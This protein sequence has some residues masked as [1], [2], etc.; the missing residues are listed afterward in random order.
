MDS[1]GDY[2]PAPSSAAAQSSPSVQAALTSL[3]VGG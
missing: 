3:K 2:K 1:D